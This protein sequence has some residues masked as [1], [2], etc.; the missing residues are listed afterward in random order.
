MFD[1]YLKIYREIST[2]TYYNFDIYHL[3]A[4]RQLVSADFSGRDLQML[5]IIENMKGKAT[6]SFLSNLFHMKQSA[7]SNRL[8]LFEKRNLIK[9]VKSD[10]DTRSIFLFIATDGL[11]LVNVY[12]SFINQYLNILKRNFSIFDIKTITSAVKKFKRLINPEI[13]DINKIDGS[14]D[15]TF[16]LRNT[17]MG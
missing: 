7:V 15:K 11:P 1:Y 9:R 12:N 13:T 10:I 4:L 16:F 5:S 17:S 2:L 3:A 8:T 6:P 14:F